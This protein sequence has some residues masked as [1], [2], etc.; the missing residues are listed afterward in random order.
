MAGKNLLGA[1]FCEI[2]LKNPTVLNSGYLGVNSEALIR[3]AKLGAGAV[4]T[5]SCG[6]KPR[7]GHPNP[8]VLQF[9]DVIINAVGLSNPGVDTEV[10]DLLRAVRE[11]N[12]P[13]I[14]SIFAESAEGY[15]EVA[16]KISK[17]KPAFIELNMSC[18]NVQVE[19][20]IPFAC[21]SRTA[22]QVVEMVK[23][24]VKIPIIAKLSPNVPDIASIA[25]SV[26]EAG[27]D[28]INAINTVGPGMVI[29]VEA[30]KPVL[31]NKVGGMSGPAVKPIAV[32][33]V[34]QI[35]RAVE[36]P[37]IGTGGIIT[38]RDAVEIMMAGAS[39]VGIGS[40]LHYRG[41]DAFKLICSEIEEFMK[42]NGYSKLEELRIEE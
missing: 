39:A 26:E 18:P 6:P 38:G 8:T 41:N 20:G 32:R 3:V 29:D 4:T 14:A 16:Q 5:K 21:D 27:A 31:A 25:K 9:G 15:V 11:T 22:A 37:V 40:A 2:E 28:A 30:R 24:S 36:I 35:S 12:V 33:C 19:M 13:V 1:K 7:G 23:G 34:W 10:P 42:K 17:A